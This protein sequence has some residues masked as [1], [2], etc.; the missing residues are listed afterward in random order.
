VLEFS[1]DWRLVVAAFAIALMAGFTG[2]S[3]TRGV[4]RRTVAQ[5]KVAV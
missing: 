4:S 2:L 3:L 1:H 5:R